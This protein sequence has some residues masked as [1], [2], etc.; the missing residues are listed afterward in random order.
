MQIGE[1]FEHQQVG[2]RVGE[3][4]NLLAEKVANLVLG[5]GGRFGQTCA[6]RKWSD[7]P[8]DECAIAGNLTYQGDPGPIDVTYTS[9]L[10]HRGDRGV[11]EQLGPVGAECVRF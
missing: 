4:Y 5:Q 10:V 6:L 1:G 3:G 11:E 9:C 2:P 8:R 7:R